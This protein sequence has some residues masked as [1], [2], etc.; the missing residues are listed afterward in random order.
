MRPLHLP[1][2]IILL[3]LSFLSF[4]FSASA[5]EAI[6]LDKVNYIA[7]SPE[8]AALHDAVNYPVEGNKG[9][10]DISIPLYTVRYGKIAIPIVLRYST[11][12]AKVDGSTAPNVGFGWV[13]D[14]GGSIN[15][16]IKGKPDE[17]SEWY[18][19]DADTHFDQLRD[20]DDQYTLSSIYGWYGTHTY[21]TE[22]DEFTMSSPSGAASFYLTESAGT[23]DGHFSPSVNW[24]VAGTTKYTGA[25]LAEMFTGLDILDGDGT[26][27]RYGSGSP[28]TTPSGADASYIEYCTYDP[29]GGTTYAT[30]WQ[31]REAEDDAGNKV[32]FTYARSGGYAYSSGQDQWY[33]VQDSVV[34]FWTAGT[35]GDG[36]AANEYMSRY[37]PTG[38]NTE[39]PYS[40]TAFR[41]V[42]PLKIEWPLGSVSF[43][44]TGNLISG[45]VIRDA[46]G[47]LV[48]S[49]S[50]GT[51]AN[52][53]RTGVPLLS[54][55]SV[56]DADS[57]LR[58]TYA[59][60]YNSLVSGTVSAPSCDWWGYFNGTT[61]S[62][63][64]YLPTRSIT[65]QGHNF[66]TSFTLGNGGHREPDT[67]LIRH[68]I[69]KAITYPGGGSTEFT[70][71]SNTYTKERGLSVTPG[72]GPGLRIRTIEYRDKDSTVLR[73][74]GYTYTD[75]SI[76]VLPAS[77]YTVD[78]S[79]QL[80]VCET[81]YISY[82]TVDRTRTV[83]PK[84][85]SRVGGGG[86]AV[87]YDKVTETVYDGETAVGRTENTFTVPSNFTLGTTGFL[88]ASEAQFPLEEWHLQGESLCYNTACITKR[89]EFTGTGQLVRRTTYKYVEDETAELVN[90]GF[91][92]G[93]Y[94]NYPQ[95]SANADSGLLPDYWAIRRLYDN[96]GP[97]GVAPLY[98]YLYTST[99]GYRYPGGE[100]VETFGIG[101][102]GAVS[103]SAFTTDRTVGYTL[104]D[105]W[106]YPVSVSTL[107][108]DGQTEKVTYTYPFRPG[109]SA[110]AMADSLTARHIVGRALSST[111]W[112]GTTKVDTTVVTYARHAGPLAPGGYFFRPSAVKHGRG[113]ATPETR[114]TYAE[115]DAWG[116][117][118][119]IVYGKDDTEN[120]IWSYSHTTPVAKVTG[121]AWGEV[122]S[123]VGST[124]LSGLEGAVTPAEASVTGALA[125]LRGIG[126]ALAEGR[127]HRPFYGVSGEYD[128]S[129][130]KRTY[131]YD[132]F[133]RLATAKDHAGN[134]VL[135]AEYRDTLGMGGSYVKVST[136]DTAMTSFGNVPA[137]HR[138]TVA[139]YYDGQYREAQSV[140]AYGSG[141]SS[142]LVLPYSTYDAWGRVTESW[143]S[144]GAGA[145]GGGYRP[146]Y[147]TEQNAFYAAL[148][149]GTEAAYARHRTEYESSPV[150]RVLR[151]YLPGSGG[152]AD[153]A[154]AVRHDYR[155]NVPQDSVYRWNITPSTSVVTR[156]G[157]YAAGTLLREVVTDPD[158]RRATTFT[159]RG[160]NVVETRVD[161]LRTSYVYDD[162]GLLVAVIP[163]KAQPAGTALTSTMYYRYVYDGRQRMTESYIPDRGKT[164]YVY[165]ADD[166]LV[167]WR[168]EVDAASRRW[169]FRRYDRLGREVYSGIVC[170]NLLSADTLR[171]RYAG[172]AFHETRSSSGPAAGYTY[173][174][175]ALPV[176]AR[177][178]PQCVLAVTYYDSYGYPDEKSFVAAGAEVGQ[179]SSSVQSTDVKGLVTGRRVKVLDG[180][181][182]TASARS[183]TTSFYYNALGEGIQE[184]GDLYPKG[185]ANMFR[186]S[187]LYRHQGEVSVTKES[188][189]AGTTTTVLRKFGY[190]AAGRLTA[191]RQSLDGG[192]EMQLEA[193][194]WDGVGRQA[195]RTL[196]AG[197][198]TVDYAW[199]IR[200]RLTA[201]NDPSSLGT[202]KFGIAYSYET[203]TLPQY[204]GNISGST[205]AHAGGST[206]GYAY[207]YDAKGRL[208]AGSHSGGNGETVSYDANGNITA[209]TRTG[210][211]AE[212]LVY[213]Y[214]AGTNRLST[215]KRNGTDKAYSFAADGTMTRDGLRGVDIGYNLLQL[216]E[217]IAAGTTVISYI[218][219]ADGNKLGVMEGR[220]MKS[221][222][223]GDFVYKSGMAV[224]Y[225]LT[226]NGQ[227]TRDAG[228]GTYTAQYD[229]T[230][231]LGSV[232]AVV[233]DGGTVLQTTDYYPFGLAFSD[234][235][236]NR[237]RYL[238]NGKELENYLT[239]NSYLGTLDYG[240]RHYD[241]RIARWPVPDP[242]AEKNYGVNT[243]A[244][245]A[246]NP[247]LL[248]DMDGK[249]PIYDLFGNFMG[250]D[251]LGIQGKPII[252]NSSSFE[253]GMSNELAMKNN[254]GLDAIIDKDHRMKLATHFAGLK[255]RPDWDGFVTIAEGVAWAKSHPNAL[256]NPTPNNT[257]YINTSLLDFGNISES[258][259]EQIGVAT[260]VNLFN[261]LNTVNS[262]L[263]PRLA[264]S[265]YALGRVNM[266]LLDRDAKSV[267][268]VND[269]NQTSNRATDYDWNLGGNK[270]RS[271]AVKV[272]RMRAR[273]PDNAGFRVYYYGTGK[274]NY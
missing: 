4:S 58:Q 77:R 103:A 154:H 78:M 159:D 231:H 129:G 36:E 263:N 45:L 171:S 80:T 271:T 51:S 185:T 101:S 109:L 91:Y 20:S 111:R 95:A 173:S 150:G 114:I 115:Y 256:E 216:P 174:D 242:M 233:D 260:P 2:R 246:G 105:P 200:N 272:E 240:A 27:Y 165:D 119:S 181:E 269:Y 29:L 34:L 189:T 261:T 59:L 206:Q 124:A 267:I 208:T 236:I 160:G 24:K 32:T 92:H 182:L 137:L 247:I 68:N 41:N 153:T 12:S 180:D 128:P 75:G 43:R 135:H 239:G 226:P 144:Y 253:Q 201:I 241:P 99:R 81:S 106:L 26:R 64:S 52:N 177:D 21:D 191:V 61:V 100:T 207:A 97:D 249:N 254:M 262:T 209:L 158:G 7:L 172:N 79:H 44:V 187:T 67:T 25:G 50:F 70:F 147:A 138:R 140:Q 213:T 72:T 84:Y 112:V 17:A 6:S 13:L 224:D 155:A 214:A 259:F 31:L 110:G 18:Q 125:S 251:N 23:Y 169:R 163:P 148:Y 156:G 28:S 192:A 93:V 3:F 141:T 19:A 211:R 184:V 22:K 145:G 120:Y 49:I 15:R 168:D 186:R 71:E 55:V 104:D 235:D 136:P 107:R 62:Q 60:S 227:M 35:S 47:T 210:T 131:A 16:M 204:G 221:A 218:Y 176:H 238:Y 90:M 225:I 56:F 73:K 195:T 222:Y 82:I 234:S 142:D 9:V 37:Y 170:D 40:L 38:E 151:E 164:E 268:I 66:S 252:M 273:I 212:T 94:Y 133:Q 88:N 244:Y 223:C 113:T 198:Q 127:T 178:V 14:V 157:A 179:S 87:D 42:Y 85:V 265:V 219:D 143:L 39:S 134:V 108:S 274:L 54:S 152:Y 116:N 1:A 53:V 167:A 194:T 126:Y 199:D 203:G 258:Q 237:N 188:Q 96:A 229:I 161:S 8:A 245:C 149:G 183:L 30:G 197:V 232:R 69:L 86:E 250:T 74:L 205:W 248:F 257:L 76:S 130:R 243:Y 230:D 202:D 83:T 33:R 102:D 215:L 5:Q 57:V 46:D 65:A 89:E 162:A 175:T 117:P 196:G 264:A 98:Y 48:R 122:V 266:M 166:R 255:T 63:N 139:R 220:T 146:D 121:A 10:P 228:T 193:D 118:R 270:V 132:A 11:S 123:A 217:S 190:D